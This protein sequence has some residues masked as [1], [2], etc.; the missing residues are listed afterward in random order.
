MKRFIQGE[1]RTQVTMFPELLDDYVAESNPVRVVD[2][3]VDELDLSE[4]GFEGVEPA[5]TGRPA[6][7]PAI[8]LKIYIYGY[9]NRI[10][11]SRR[12]EREAQRNVELMWLTGRLMPDFKTI[13]NFRK[14]NGKAI[15]KVCRQFIVLCQQLDLFSDAL[16]AIDGSKFKAVNNRDRNFT[17]AKLQRRME[18]I[19]SSINRYLVALDTADRQEPKVAQLRRARLEDKIAALKTQMQALKE[20]EVVLN[21]T[22]DKQISLTDPDA[23]SM[24]T[25]GTGIVGYNVQTAVDAKHHL[26]VA[27]EVTN[28]GRDHEQ[29]TSMAKQAREAMGTQELTA[30]ADR[31][32][33]KSQEIL[34]SHEAGIA[35]IVPKPETSTPAANGLFGKADFIYDAERDEYRCPAGKVLTRHCET[36][37]NEMKMYRYWYTNCKSCA[38]KDQC[39]PGN[40]RRVTRWENEEILEAMQSRLDHTPDAMRIRR[41]TVEHPFGTLK[42]WMG[43]AHFL[44]KTL[45]RVSTEMSLHVL[46]YNMKRM[47]KILGTVALMEAM[48][49]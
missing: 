22:P 48:V 20:V 21:E 33:F 6:Y 39:T 18:E 17:S 43:S 44:T 30:I 3:F 1:D 36:T 45:D 12:L 2:V 37:Q 11:S 35:V 23:R 9:L 25:R 49:A 31:G 19:E 34:A 41:Q 16:V 24:K 13:A 28:V 10:Q 29:L 14:D 46:A 26:I 27:H 32:Y 40:E 15:R 5:A 47:M 4:L 38:M 42:L 8:L 7:H